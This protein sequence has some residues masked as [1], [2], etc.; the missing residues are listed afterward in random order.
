MAVGTD[1]PEI[2]QSI[3]VS[4]PVD[5]I[6]LERDRSAVPSRPSAH[7]A[8]MMLETLSDQTSL[9]TVGLPRSSLDEQ[10]RERGGWYDRNSGAPPPSLAHEMGRVD[11][12]VLY[13]P[14]RRP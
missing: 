10:F 4:S 13:A 7:L 14:R 6:E 9:E 12:D 3:V 11:A 5:V 1:D 2:G 8:H